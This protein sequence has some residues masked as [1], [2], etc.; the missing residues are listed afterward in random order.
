MVNS[1]GLKYVGGW[2]EHKLHGEGKWT[3]VD[4]I[5]VAGIWQEGK[6]AQLGEFVYLERVKRAN[7]AFMNVQRMGNRLRI[8][9]MEEGE[10]EREMETWGGEKLEVMEAYS[11]K[12]GTRYRR[13]LDVG[14]SDVCSSRSTISAERKSSSLLLQEERQVS[15]ASQESA[16]GPRK[17]SSSAQGKEF[18]P[19]LVQGRDLLLQE[20]TLMAGGGEGGRSRDTAGYAKLLE[21]MPDAMLFEVGFTSSNILTAALKNVRKE[22]GKRRGEEGKR[23]GEEG[24]G[25]GI[26]ERY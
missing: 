16:R 3:F 22:G 1:H 4:G 21:G 18:A 9:E 13:A 19:S 26:G 8:K 24:R 12:E 23:E 17:S 5:E 7:K 20:E 2:K 15:F 25:E 14:A 10:K 11:K 6:V